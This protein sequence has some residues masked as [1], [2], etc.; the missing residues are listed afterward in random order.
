MSDKTRLLKLLDDFNIPYHTFEDIIYM[1]K[2]AV[3]NKAVLSISIAGCVDFYFDKEGN[4]IGHGTEYRDA[5][6]KAKRK[7]K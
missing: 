5:F 6:V 4:K 2:E 3:E 7:K 1:C